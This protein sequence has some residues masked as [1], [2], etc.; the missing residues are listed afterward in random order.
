MKS[1][2]LLQSTG[3]GEA[4]YNHDWVE[5]SIEYKKMM[6]QI[7]ERAQVPACIRAPTCP[8]TNYETFMGVMSTSYKFLTILRQSLEME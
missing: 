8:V 3:V 1:L 4:V 5:G 2:C 7:I 6:V